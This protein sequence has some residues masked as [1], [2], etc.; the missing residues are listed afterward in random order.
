MV[1]QSF[2][3]I[4]FV[5][6]NLLIINK[7]AGL[8][9]LPDGYNPTL[10][11]IRS[12]L[13]PEYGRLWIVHRL[14]KE[15]S[16]VMILTRS[17]LA[18]KILNQQFQ[19]RKVDKVYHVIVQGCPNWNSIVIDAPLL[20]DGDRRHR[21]TINFARGKPASTKC[22]V[23]KRME[24]STLLSVYPMSGYTHQIRAHLAS[25]GFPLL[26][27]PLYGALLPSKKDIF[28]RAALHAYQI[29]FLHPISTQLLNF[30]APYP[31]DFLSYLNQNQPVD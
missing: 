23:L 1:L 14:D 6:P 15:T 31:D 9:S 21:T 5:D 7:P 26:S 29:H 17:P 30:L 19:D 22:D 13:E 28:Q 20:I 8:L 10:P 11:Y 24:K 18:H 2:L 25:I 3:E 12:I 27:D 4:I 16:G